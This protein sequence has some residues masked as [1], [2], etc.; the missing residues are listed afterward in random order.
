VLS[1]HSLCGMIPDARIAAETLRQR[2]AFQDIS[3]L[4]A[5]P[6]NITFQPSWESH[7]NAVDTTRQFGGAQ[8][9]A[10]GH[11]SGKENTLIPRVVINRDSTEAASPSAPRKF[12]HCRVCMTTVS[13]GVVC[14][15]PMR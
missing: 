6:Q 10:F 11:L 1:H 2:P 5:L 8:H 14:Q 3:L 15:S 4:F 9:I 13:G 7:L 12:Q